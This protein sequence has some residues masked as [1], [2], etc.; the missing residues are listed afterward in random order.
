MT[1]RLQTISAERHLAF[2]R[3]LPSASHTQLPSW[4]GVK[5]D[6]RAESVGWTDPAD[7][8][9]VGVGLV[10]YRPLPKLRRYLAYLPEGP[11]I[12]WFDPDLRRWLDPLVAHLRA[13]GAFSVRM[14]PPVV[15]RRWAA[16]TVK[17]AIGDPRVRRLGDVRP[18]WSDPRGD[19]LMA[20]LRHLGW[21]A[22]P[23]EAAGGGFA[24]GQ[25]RH[26][27]QLPVGGRTLQEIQQGFNQQWRRNIKKADKAGVKVVPGGYDE[28][29]AFY[30]LYEETAQRD[31]FV[32]RP[33]EY[34]QRMWRALSAEDPDRMRLYLAQH[35]GDVLAAATVLTVGG[36]AWYS[37]GASTGRKREV[38]PNNAIQWQM[39]RDAHARGATV[40]D[41]RGITDTLDESDPHIGLLRFKVGTGGEAAE[42][43]GEWDLPINRLL[44]R[45]LGLYLAR[46]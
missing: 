36:H 24:A 5:P 42:Y 8:R 29:P 16:E 34:F 14:G 13:Q 43:V 28:L 7:D 19:E 33:P 25:P 6:W 35:D 22:A 30:R 26:V 10:L 32:P 27:F 4:G 38:Q 45:A 39:I 2:V 17:E 41:F 3:T 40:Y 15:F 46:R 37:Y 9:L 11:V 31:R 23:D 12:D 20:R 44:H 18:T 1:L 21:H